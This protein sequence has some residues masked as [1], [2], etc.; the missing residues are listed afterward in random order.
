MYADSARF[1]AFASFL[2]GPPRGVFPDFSVALRVCEERNIR[3]DE[4]L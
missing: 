1:G 4:R 2:R 3:T